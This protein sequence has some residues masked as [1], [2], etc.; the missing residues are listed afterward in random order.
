MKLGISDRKQSWIFDMD[1]M[2]KTKDTET[3]ADTALLGEIRGMIEQARDFVAHTA[4]STLTMLYWKIGERIRREVL[5]EARAE[6]GEEIL[7]TLSAKLVV[8]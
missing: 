1:K 3:P 8:A 6:Y 7:P 5:Q 2:A 4:N